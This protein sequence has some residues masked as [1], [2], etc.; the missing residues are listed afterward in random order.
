VTFASPYAKKYKAG[1]LAFHSRE[2]IT[3]KAR[4]VSEKS[5]EGTGML[6]ATEK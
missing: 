2:D 6:I 3:H 1:S 5:K 4:V